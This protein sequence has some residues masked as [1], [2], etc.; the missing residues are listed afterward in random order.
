MPPRFLLLLLWLAAPA[1][2][3]VLFR[4][5]FETGDLSQW[6]ATG[7]RGQNATP[8]N[9]QVVSDIVHEGRYAVR[10]TIHPDDVF[11][12]RQL[13]V[14]L[15]GPRVTVEEGAETYL[16]FSL[17][18]PA[19]AQDRDNFFYWEGNP[20]PRYNNVMTWW[21]EP[22]AGGT[23]LIKYG[24]GNLGRNGTHWQAEF[25]P[26]QWHRL[27]MH[28]RWSEDETKGHVRL[29]FD[30]KLVLD[31]A[32]KTKGPEAVYFCQP[33]I[34]RSPHRPS[35]DTIYFDNFILAD[36][37][38]EIEAAPT[39][40]ALAGDWAVQVS[41]PGVPADT[42]AVAPPLIRSVTAEKHDALPVYN[43]QAGGWARGARLVGL[44]SQETTS[45]YLLDPASFALRAGPAPD[46]ALFTAGVDYEIDPVWGTFG[47][48]AGG[49]IG[50]EQPVYAT[51][52]HAEMRLDAVVLTAAGTLALRPGEPRAAAPAPAPLV[53]GDR[54]LGNVFVPRAIERL[55]AD[56]LF[57]I[58]ETAYPEPPRGERHPVIARLVRRLEAGEPLRI[59]A[60]GDSVTDAGYLPGGATQRWQEQFAAR[61]RQK[62]PRARIEMITEAWG[63]RNT[64]SYLA[65]PP[66]SAHNYQEKVLALKPDLIISEFVNDS[67]LTPA[68]VEER[69][70]KLL[71]DFE[72]IGAAWIILTPHYVQAQRMNFTRE[73]EIDDDPRPYVAGLRQFTARHGVPLADASLRYGR[74]WR[75]GIPYSTLLLNAINHP[76]AYG[77]RLFADALLALFR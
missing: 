25:T 16:G 4:A 5:D 23:T 48:L 31:Q 3:R 64:S 56:H 27:A 55:T 69:Y 42:L 6:A 21:V 67:S 49:R 73:R 33:G 28:I 2:G 22:G 60:W 14:Q 40:F 9:V 32:L 70:S 34:H 18:M 43:P 75:Q 44:R 71:A 1:A 58:L 10:M 19:A 47:R 45:A 63:G 76:D 11:N 50:A 51:Y 17:Y 65:E 41:R 35:V 53:A 13:R 66:G 57:P 30:G 59:L 26:G 46:A 62:F 15:G 68:R 7:T 77:M 61:L 8:R 38:A 36:T 29:W 54:L 74:L 72:A 12:D 52:R 24:T 39:T 20:P 37:L